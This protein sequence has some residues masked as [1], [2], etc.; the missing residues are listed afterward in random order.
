MEKVKLGDVCKVQGGYAFKSKEFQKDS[1]PIIRIG[2]IQDNEVEID[3]NVCFT[4]EFLNKHPEFEIKYGDILIAMSGAT[5]GKIGKYQN[6]TKALLNQRVGNF[7]VTEKL[8]KRYLYFLLQ[9][10]LFEKFILNNAF[11]CAQHNISSKQI[12]G[13]EF[14]NYDNVEQ[15][16]IANQLD[17]VQEII[18]FR[19]KQIQELDE[20]IKSQFVEMFGDPIQNDKNWDTDIIN[21]VAP[22]QNYKGSFEDKVWLLNL[23]MVESNSGRIIDYVYE[24]INNIGNSTCTFNEENIL[25]SKLRPY[26]NKVVI[27][28]QKG[29]ATSELV[30]LRPNMDKI[31]R[32][33]L[34]YLLR[35]EQ[36]VQYI[37]EKVAGAKMPRVSMD[38]FRKFNLIIPPIELQNKFAEV[39]K[40]I[41]KQKFE[42]QKSLEE[43][44]KLQESLMNKYFG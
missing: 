37:S 20:L 10:P 5:V 24:N 25:Y 30:P 14:Y 29:Y 19:K 27:P 8:E 23:D 33:F 4:K 28:N 11:G 22:S 31:N 3:Y 42:I 40:Q 18:D 16:E 35:S 34:A 15:I 1:I 26:L 9:S 36:F 32:Y 44:Q 12:E 41:D 38:M 43:T 21:N 39:V 13:F 7:I 17:K 2:N 6:D